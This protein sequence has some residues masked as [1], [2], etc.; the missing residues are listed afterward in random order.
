MQRIVKCG[1]LGLEYD[2][3]YE[4]TDGDD[5]D[6]SFKYDYR[7][8]DEKRKAR[9]QEEKKISQEKAQKKR[10]KKENQKKRKQLEREKQNT[11]KGEETKTDKEETKPE[12]SKATDEEP[13]KDKNTTVKQSIPNTAAES[14]ESEGNDDEG[15]QSDSCDFE[16]LDI[17]ST[18]VTKAILIAKRKMEQKPHPEK[19]E[20]KKTPVKERKLFPVKNNELPEVEEKFEQVSLSPHIPTIEDNIKRSTEHAVNGN[21][22]ASSGYFNM[23]VKCFTEAIKYN[24]TEF[25][26]FGNRSFCFEK[27]QEYEKALIDAELSLSICPGWVKG[28]F[29]KGKALAGLKMYEEAAQAFS[30]VLKLDSSYAEAAQE[31]LRV[32]II[33]LMEYGFTREQSSNAIIIHG[34]VKKSLEVLSQFNLQQGALQQTTPVQ[35]VNVGGVSPVLSAN[36]NHPRGAVAA[37]TTIDAALPPHHPHL[38]QSHNPTN[39]VLHNAKSIEFQNSFI[40]QRQHKP[41]VDEKSSKEN[42]QPPPE[43]FPVW[44]GNLFNP[45]N[46]SVLTN[47]FSMAG[48]VYSVKILSFKCCA[49]VNFTKQEF[50]DEAIRR[51]NGF[52]LDGM[53]IVVRYSDRIPQGLGISKSALTSKDV[54]NEYMRQH[55]F[56]GQRSVSAHRFDQR[57]K[58]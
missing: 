6:S 18:F 56:V 50:C 1:L 41:S 46:E 7:E 4:D 23:A 52:E 53:K 33:Q 44:V 21:K 43:L 17:N 15:G 58:K 29:R 13:N 5:T 11:L 51:F 39:A 37:T 31:L 49:F 35:V 19:K 55:N 40:V 2:Y 3:D 28:L 16:E 36:K 30:E 14:N 25:R 42:S 9:L 34:T 20:K 45:V 26:L 54:Q 8:T 47:L 48:V 32:Q 22:F 12:G 57:D 10:L 27:M 38:P 24:P